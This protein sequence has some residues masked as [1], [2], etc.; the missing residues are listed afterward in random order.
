VL[1]N[2]VVSAQSEEGAMGEICWICNATKKEQLC[3]THISSS[4]PREF[5]G[6]QGSAAM[7]TWYLSQNRGD[8]ITFISDYDDAKSLPFGLKL[9]EIRTWPDKTDEVI[10]ELINQGIL[11][12]HGN[13][14]E[15]E[16]D[17]KNVYIR[18]LQNIWQ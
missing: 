9:E 17:P 15:D 18:N 5:S 11:K 3:F 14:F 7:V 2:Q 12:D 6:N 10:N 4:T 13:S 16:D 1:H 8:L